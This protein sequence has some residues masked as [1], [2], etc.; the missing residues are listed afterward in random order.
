VL[1][2]ENNS[3]KRVLIVSSH[4]LFGQGIRS[5]LM[6]RKQSEVEVVAVVSGLSDAIEALEIYK[7]DL[8][9]VDYDDQSLNNEDIFAHFVDDEKQIRVVMLSLADVEHAQVYDRRTMKASQID[10]WFKFW[11][12]SD[13]ETPAILSKVPLSTVRRI[14][15]KHLVIA[16][17]LAI[18]VTALLI[19]GLNQ[20]HLLPVEASAQAIPIDWMFGLEFKVIAFLFALIVVFLVYSIV[21]FRRKKGDLTDGVYITGNKHLE[22]TWTILPLF[23]VLI[24]SYLG[25]QTLS[26]TLRVDPQAM[27]V[28]VI[29][30]QWNWRFEYPNYGFSSTDLVL[31]VNQQVLLHIYSTDVIHSFWVPEFRVKQDALPGGI[32]N[33]RQLRITPTQI[34]EYKV[35][36]AELCGLNHA[37][38]LAPVMVKTNADFNTWLGQQTGQSNDPVER[39]KKWAQQY[40]CVACHSADGSK[41]VGPTW[42]GLY[43]SQVTLEDGSQVTADE[44][45][46]QESIHQPGAK[47]VQG[48]TNIMPASI[49]AN[50][51][52]QQISDVIDYIKSL[53]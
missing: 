2:K 42:K 14:D 33:A 20:V 48:F 29:A 8:V 51:T 7:P 34:G 17:L 11:N 38:M 39:G 50:M 52:D 5:L 6:E 9:I 45:Y 13:D 24:F 25:A 18:I 3:P 27:E 46:L 53:K 47:I 44:T 40:G 12:S 21:V 43:D 23:T 19:L 41:G 26:E 49:A 4:A 1:G 30:S 31:P 32:D 16:G 10:D 36:C 22:V 35:R 37:Y 15:M 28:N